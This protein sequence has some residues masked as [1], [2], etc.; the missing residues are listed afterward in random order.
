MPHS[1]L[2]WTVFAVVAPAFATAWISPLK[3]LAIFFYAP[4]LR[5]IA[6]SLLQLYDILLAAGGI[7]ATRT[8]AWGSTRLPSG[9]AVAIFGRA[10]RFWAPALAGLAAT[11]SWLPNEEQ[12]VYPAVIYIEF[13]NTE[14]YR[15]Y[16]P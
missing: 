16:W 5:A 7:Q 10:L 6:K 13:T 9:E 2:P 12:V 15:I 8:L 1:A 4:R 11:A 3:A 14:N